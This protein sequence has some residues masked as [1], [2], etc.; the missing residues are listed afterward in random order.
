MDRKEI[1]RR[2]N[3]KMYEKYGR[4]A[5]YCD[6]KEAEFCKEKSASLGIN[7]ADLASTLGMTLKECVKIK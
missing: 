3:K 2:S 6:K 4:I 1:L 5:F 7:L